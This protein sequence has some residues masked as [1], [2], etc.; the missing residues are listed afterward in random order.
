LFVQKSFVVVVLVLCIWKNW[1]ACAC[2]CV[3]CVCCVA[4]VLPCVAMCACCFLR[5]FHRTG[6]GCLVAV[7]A[8][9]RNGAAGSA[10]C[11]TL[12]VA[13]IGGGGS[14]AA[15]DGVGGVPRE[16]VH[17]AVKEGLGAECGGLPAVASL[18]GAVRSRDVAPVAAAN[19]SAE[20]PLALAQ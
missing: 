5:S 7:W 11:R 20:M 17:V 18:H 15:A 16:P 13:E 8:P 6:I 4:S 19:A 3:H 9:G 12:A 10:A 1:G 14:A 2:G